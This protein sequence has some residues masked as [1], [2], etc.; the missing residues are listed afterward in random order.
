M[1][2][3]KIPDLRTDGIKISKQDI[4]LLVICQ[5]GVVN[6]DQLWLTG[7]HG[8]S[9]ESYRIAIKELKERNLVETFF[10]R[11]RRI[12]ISLT[13][14]GK[15]YVKHV[16]GEDLLEE[17]APQLVKTVP[18]RTS[19]QFLHRLNTNTFYCCYLSAPGG[20]ISPWILEYPYENQLP[21]YGEGV[22]RSDGYLETPEGMK[23]FVEQDNHTQRAAALSVK[24]KKYI[25]SARFSSV[26][27]IERNCLLFCVDSKLSEMKMKEL[28]K[29]ESMQLY[30][31]CLKILKLWRLM[32]HIKGEKLIFEDILAIM[33]SREE[34]TA[35]ECLF[36][37]KERK[38]ALRIFS[39]KNELLQEGIQG[40]EEYKDTSRLAS[41]ED[42][43]KMDAL[44]KA[45]DR[46]FRDQ[47][48]S[49]LEMTD[50]GDLK[51]QLSKGMRIYLLPLHDIKSQQ[52]HLMVREFQ[53][54]DVYRKCMA[55][56]GLNT[57]DQKLKFRPL[58]ELRNIK[59]GVWFRNVFV[60]PHMYAVWE[61]ISADMGAY[62]R[63]TKFL[64]ECSGIEMAPPLLFVLLVRSKDQA[65]FFYESVASFFSRQRTG[66][67]VLSF[68]VKDKLFFQN[69]MLSPFGI[70]K[71]EGK[72]EV[73]T[74][75]VEEEHGKIIEYW[76]DDP[77]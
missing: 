29:R 55:C 48:L 74:L 61:D 25:A 37:E 8:S 43:E 26:K 42:Q 21:V 45:F 14:K 7:N 66:K 51:K 63:V 39:A 75:F 46:R 62:Y 53:M 44:D 76:E 9:K 19:P 35:L 49:L 23:Y 31:M 30:R 6:Y 47:Y 54:E 52:P 11:E 12:A 41:V 22:N 69:L 1:P 4:D 50:N 65:V 77:C 58:Y 28:R 16:F 73:G 20:K 17:N 2:K 15:E 56:M 10:Y 68:L 24:I 72:W 34:K 5:A 27:E 18:S 13:S 40:F 33:E 67:I 64:R 60:W 71:R 3:G 36:T 32:E 59:A 38:E 70:R 57:S